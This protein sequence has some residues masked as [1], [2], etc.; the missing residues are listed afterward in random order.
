MT[1]KLMMVLCGMM[2]MLTMCFVAGKEVKA[3]V[4]KD[5]NFEYEIKED[6]TIA[7]TDYYGTEG[8][9][10]IPEEINGSIVDEIGVDVFKNSYNLSNI[11]LPSNLSKIGSGAFFGCSSLKEIIIPNT[12]TEINDNVF[13]SCTS[14]T[15]VVLPSNLKR[16]EDG[17]F[18]LCFQLREVNIPD[19]L[20][21][22]G[23]STF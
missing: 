18:S 12:V 8:N 1:K 23:E 17:L 19:K 16:L 4:T 10:T 21:S 14:L 20:E 7:I 13:S 15:R 2:L 22:I 9:V 5:G 11:T 3:E 6:G